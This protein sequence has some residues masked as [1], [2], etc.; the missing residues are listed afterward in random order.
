MV[1]LRD[2]SFRKL[3]EALDVLAECLGDPRSKALH[4]SRELMTCNP[5]RMIFLGA[6]SS[7]LQ[8]RLRG[9]D[10]SSNKLICEGEFG[11]SWISRGISLLS[12]KPPSFSTFF[13][14]V[15]KH[16]FVIMSFS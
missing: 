1:P 13:F 4:R 9:R 11:S 10:Q 3:T 16:S 6:R 8:S 5:I 2:Q 7:S 12:C 14:I 15:G